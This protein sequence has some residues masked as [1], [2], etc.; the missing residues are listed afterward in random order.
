MDGLSPG[1]VLADRFVLVAPLREGA[2]AVV[3]SAV[4]QTDQGEVALKF[5]AGPGARAALAEEYARLSAIDHPAVVRPLALGEEDPPFLALERIDGPELRVEM[6]ADYRSWLPKLRPALDGLAAAHAAGVAHGDL[7]LQNILLGDDG[8]ARL[9]DFAPR[10]DASVRGDLLALGA[11]LHKLATGIAPDADMQA[12]SRK[13]LPDD[14]QRLIRDLLERPDEQDIARVNARIDALLAGSVDTAGQFERIAPA[15]RR[16]AGRV[17]QPSA[18]GA[19]E[20]RWGPFAVLTFAALALVIVFF[21]WSRF[22]SDGHIDNGA[23]T[24]QQAGARLAAQRDE[25]EALRAGVYEKWLQLEGMQVQE[26]ASLRAD[27]ARER[28]SAGERL[29]G[30][31]DTLAALREL[32]EAD[33]LMTALIDE[34]PGIGAFHREA[35]WQAWR[36]GDAALAERHFR[37][38]LAIDPSDEA[39]RDALGRTQFLDAVTALRRTATEQRALGDPGAALETLREAARIDAGNRE[40]AAEIAELEKDLEHTRFARSMSTVYAALGARRYADARKALATA[41]SL[42]GDAPEVHDARTQLAVAEREAAIASLRA[43]ASEAEQAQDWERAIALYAELLE[44]DSALVFA[45][46]GRDRARL[47]ASLTARAQALLDATE[48][49]RDETRRQ[50][51][52]IIEQIGAVKAEAS[53]LRQL[54]SRLEERLELSRQ[55]VPVQLRSD[56]ETEVTIYRVGKLGRFATETIELIPGRYTVIGV[57][58]GFRDVRRE[59][60]VRAGEPVSPFVIQCE[61]RI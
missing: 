40:I 21:A 43:Q 36:G 11:T 35:G 4:D 32:R 31:L 15:Q 39:V 49:E 59:L 1:R 28:L 9:I 48:F 18:P 13:N 61:E 44:L 26:W 55:P 41:A 8:R 57:R 46:Q 37:T 30:E 38:V 19:A 50:A 45:L 14:L 5:L 47:L 25:A 53:A 33:A 22:G 58:D 10:P 16:R 54:A 60:V 56:N 29:L 34:A 23:D 3:W 51:Q 12:M 17:V 52:S 24:V 20:N 7:S 2:S 42:R 27:S 6:G